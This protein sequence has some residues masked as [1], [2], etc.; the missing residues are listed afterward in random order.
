MGFLLIDVSRLIGLL[1]NVVSGGI[2]VADPIFLVSHLSDC[3]ANL[4]RVA[5]DKLGV[6]TADAATAVIGIVVVLNLTGPAADDI[7]RASSPTLNPVEIF[8]VSAVLAMFKLA[9]SS[10]FSGPFLGVGGEARGPAHGSQFDLG[11][12]L[13]V[14]GNHV[15]G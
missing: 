7:A 6:V 10:Q 13:V 3:T 4:R 11:T 15:L 1:A 12:D 8:A 14:A 5:P 9:G 2:V